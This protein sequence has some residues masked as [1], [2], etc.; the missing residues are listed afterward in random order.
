MFEQTSIFDVL[1]PKYKITKPIRLIEF[2]AGYGSQAL[3]LKYLGVKFEHWK[4]C[5]WA[6][7]SIQAYKDI[8]FFDKNINFNNNRTK[9]EMVEFLYNKG[10]SS[11][12]NEPMTKEQIKRLNEDTL[13]KIIT[14]IAITNNLVN[15]QQVKGKDL[16]I[17][18]TD[19]YEYILTYSFPCQDLSL[20]GK[21]K[22]MSDT[23]TRSGMLWEVERIL[24]ECYE[25][26]SLPQVLLMENVP[27]VHGTDNVED[28]NKWKY[29]L[30]ELGYKN[31][32]QDLIAT[33]YGI[34]QTRNRTF[35]ISILGDYS[36]TFPKPI[37]LK[38]KLKDMLEDEVDEKYYLSDK[39]LAYCFG[40]NQKESKYNRREVFERNLNPNKDVASTITTCARNRAT[41]NFIVSNKVLK[42]TFEQNEIGENDVQ[43]I[44]GFNRKIRKDELANTIT[45]RVSASS[46]DYILIK[47][48]TKK[49]Y[50]EA[51]E[52][53]GVDISSRMEYHRG[54]VQKG[55]S[56]TLTTMGG[57]NNGVV[58]KPKVLT[59][60]GKIGSTGQYHQQN[61]VYDDNVAISVTTAFNPYYLSDLAIRKLTP[62]EC[63]RLMG[64]RDEDITNML[65]N[66]SDS[67]A[68]HCFGDSIVV[69]VLMAIFK[70]L[71]K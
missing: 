33:D 27:Q 15:I 25:L 31:Y 35:M 64:V 70:E 66:Q 46:N 68:Y 3:A 37:P 13:K 58:I 11:N 5:E 52:G 65:K 39:M 48:A 57:E 49:G 8:H 26:G 44:D 18:N 30:E 55:K 54:T 60:F 53:D 45:T 71:I 4:T 32:F 61:R 59:G 22:G 1:Y 9:E 42:E 17:V 10:I 21:G 41:D 56:Q 38:L 7:K 16:E 20:A 40:I 24:C 2:F 43:Y 69:D 28:F 50:L 12:Y 47:N 23:S 29:K 67:S 19:K 51:Q 6:I 14:N 34:P 36:Y 63:G 62:R